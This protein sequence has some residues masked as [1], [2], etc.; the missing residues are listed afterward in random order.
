M[1]VYAGCKH[2][3]GI[4]HQLVTKDDGLL[5]TGPSRGFAKHSVEFNW[6]YEGSGPAQLALAI[7][8][9]VTGDRDIALRYYQDFKR[10]FVAGWGDSWQITSVEV[11][12]WLEF[13]A[14]PHWIPSNPDRLPGDDD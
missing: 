14:E 4:G 9:D 13:E 8:L 2:N 1:T 11:T 10:A 12:D 3:N 6:G 5:P 7:I